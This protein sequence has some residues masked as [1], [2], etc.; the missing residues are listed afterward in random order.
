MMTNTKHDEQAILDVVTGM[1]SAWKAG[2]AAA[3]V[4]FFTED[5][6]QT[7]WTG[8]Y[9]KGRS[10]IR[11][12][13]QQIFD[14]IYKDTEMEKKVKA[15]RFITPD[16]CL[17]HLESEIVGPESSLGSAMQARPLLVLKRQEDDRW[18]IETMHNTPVVIDGVIQGLRA[19]A[20]TAES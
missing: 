16:V 7:V 6:D 2:D 8:R 5:A 12:G 1:S 14:T 20:P 10:A 13:H 17:V 18:L 9:L 15:M 19:P 4:E 3:L 11:E